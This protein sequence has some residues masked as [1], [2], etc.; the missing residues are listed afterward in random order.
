MVSTTLQNTSPL[1]L[2]VEDDPGDQEL[3]RRAFQKSGFEADLRIMSDGQEAMDYLLR[4]GAFSD[5]DFAPRPDVILLDLNMQIMS[6]Q[7]VLQQIATHRDLRKIPVVV[8]TMWEQP[9]NIL[10]SYGF[11]FDSFITKPATMDALVDVI[12]TLLCP[13]T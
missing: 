8:L 3:V 2:L 12:Q 6:G 4:Q 11:G 13:C 7:E 9:V 10:K 1:V 5:P